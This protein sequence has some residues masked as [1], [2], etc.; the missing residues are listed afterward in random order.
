MKYV[1]LLIGIFTTMLSIQTAYLLKKHCATT[2]QYADL[3]YVDRAIG[4]VR[5]D[6]YHDATQMVAAIQVAVEYF[7]DYSDQNNY[8]VFESV[9]KALEGHFEAE[10]KK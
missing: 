9:M 6:T 5:D 7:K 8:V 2:T 3:T 4:K 10:E 1:Y